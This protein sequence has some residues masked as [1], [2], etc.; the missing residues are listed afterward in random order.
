M[1]ICGYIGLVILKHWESRRLDF[2]GVDGVLSGV[3]AFGLGP[4]YYSWEVTQGDFHC[5]GRSCTTEN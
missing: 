4:G 1:E 2:W 3:W 5:Q